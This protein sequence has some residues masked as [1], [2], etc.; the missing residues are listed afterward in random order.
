M[1]LVPLRYCPSADINDDGEGHANI[2]SVGGV[3]R[4]YTL[5]RPAGDS[6][7]VGELVHT[8]SPTLSN[9]LAGLPA[10]EKIGASD[11]A[12]YRNILTVQLDPVTGPPPATP[13]A[14]NLLMLGGAGIIAFGSATAYA[15]RRRRV[16]P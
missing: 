2:I 9:P 16:A 5:Q 8:T 1:G 14:P 11:P 15:R 12:L 13:E 3:S 6:Q 10:S 4:L 7:G